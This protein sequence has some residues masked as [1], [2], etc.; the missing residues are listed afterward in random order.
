MK[1]IFGTYTPDQKRADLHIHSNGSPDG[2][3]GP[4]QIVDLA[5]ATQRLN[6]IDITD[7]DTT[8]PAA[9]AKEYGLRNSYSLDVVVGAEITTTEGHLLGLYLEHDIQSRN[10]AE[11][12]IKQV[13]RQGGLA[14]VAHPL[15]KR[16][17]SS[18][19]E[20]TLL[21]LMANPD[22]EVQLDGYEVYNAGVNS[23]SD[24]ANAEA[25][26][27]YLKY[28][29]QLGAPIGST[30]MHYFVI[31]R[32]LTGYKGELYN[33]IKSS[34]TTVLYLEQEEI[35]QHTELAIKLFP[36]DVKRLRSEWSLTE[37]EEKEEHRK[38]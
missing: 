5:V 32:G 4:L 6:T 13:H 10:S 24:T 31:G 11:W 14:I 27:F 15:F 37:N 18:F 21:A 38:V 9:E 8:R 25:T 16:I 26:T 12:T 3:L 2:H 35:D 23:H 29:G 22:P 30:D 34:Q 17:R 28:E 36:E 19:T 20:E 7:H 33:A 1:E